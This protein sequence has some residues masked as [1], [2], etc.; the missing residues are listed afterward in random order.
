MCCFDDE[1]SK[2]GDEFPECSL[3]EKVAGRL[4]PK[5]ARDYELTLLAKTYGPRTFG[6]LVT[7][8]P[9]PEARDTKSACDTSASEGNR[10][11]RISA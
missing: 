2:C 7:L 10:S 1:C 11:S 9:A 4:C 8:P 5:C 3:V 6:Y